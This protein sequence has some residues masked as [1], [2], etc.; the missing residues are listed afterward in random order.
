MLINHKDHKGH[1]DQEF[2]K[3]RAWRAA[4]SS[5]W[6]RPWRWARNHAPTATATTPNIR[7]SWPTS[8]VGKIMRATPPRVIA[9]LVVTLPMIAFSGG[10]ANEAT[11][12]TKRAMPTQTMLLRLES[13]AP[14][15][16]AESFWAA[17]SSVW[18]RVSSRSVRRI[19]VMEYWSGGVVGRKTVGALE[20]WSV[21]AL[22]WPDGRMYVRVLMVS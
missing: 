20:R 12:K 8:R 21:E 4:E 19:G 16:R 6:R 9:A 10:Q 2:Q 3:G 13:L 22:N 11:P 18:A 17:P 7:S 14:S 15:S 5:P 1:R